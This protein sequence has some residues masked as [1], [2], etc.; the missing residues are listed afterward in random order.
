MRLTAC[1]CGAQHYR[2]GQ[3]AWW[4]KLLRARRLYHCYSCD[5]TMLI[6]PDEVAQRLA[7]HERKARRASRR[8]DMA[9]E[10]S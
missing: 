8:A 7:R 10:R 2:R 3:R 1:G 5:E 6:S 9:L 4:M